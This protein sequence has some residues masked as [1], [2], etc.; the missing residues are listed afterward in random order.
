MRVF[1]GTSC[2]VVVLLNKESNGIGFKPDHL[3]QKEFI[4]DIFTVINFTL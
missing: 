1:F 3:E 4:L 2:K